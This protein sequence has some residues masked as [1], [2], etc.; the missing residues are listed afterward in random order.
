MQGLITLDNSDKYI[1]QAAI[2]K[3]RYALQVQ[4]KSKELV[5][6]LNDSLLWTLHYCKKHNIPLPNMEKIRN[7]IDKTIELELETSPDQ[8]QSNR[9]NNYRGGNSTNLGYI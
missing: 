9:E 8:P 1:E 5:E 3:L 6:H 4:K 7:I 2:E